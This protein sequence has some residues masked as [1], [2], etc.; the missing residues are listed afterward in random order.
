MS[1]G[2]AA[3]VVKSDKSQPD[4]YQ[5]AALLPKILYLNFYRLRDISFTLS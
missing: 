2:N 3:A 1:L 4:S 5:F